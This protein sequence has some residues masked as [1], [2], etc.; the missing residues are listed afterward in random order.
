MASKIF[1]S[2][3]LIFNLYI[4][5][6]TLADDYK[7]HNYTIYLWKNGR[8]PFKLDEYLSHKYKDIILESMNN[9]HQYT[10]I[11]FIPYE[12]KYHHHHHHHI[13]YYTNI[14][15]GKKFSTKPG[16]DKENYVTTVTLNLDEENG[17]RQRLRAITHE[18]AHVVGLF[19]EHQRPDRDH[20]IKSIQETCSCT[21]LVNNKDWN[22]NPYKNVQYYND[23]Q[24]QWITTIDDKNTSKWFDD[25]FDMK[26]ITYYPD[27][28]IKIDSIRDE[29]IFYYELSLYDIKKIKKLYNCKRRKRPMN[30]NNKKIY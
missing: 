25:Y 2:F 6:T 21:F 13:Y 17:Y 30:N 20:Y 27:C 10:C 8:I 24:Q 26:S 7:R 22:C 28:F 18:L 11:R 5:T 4:I 3:F 16:V 29:P 12:S 1:L 19:H 23:Y 9:F 14:I 15:K